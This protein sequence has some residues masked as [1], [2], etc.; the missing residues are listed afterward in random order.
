MV[1]ELSLNSHLRGAFVYIP[2]KLAP[3]VQYLFEQIMK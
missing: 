1:R 2:A 3:G